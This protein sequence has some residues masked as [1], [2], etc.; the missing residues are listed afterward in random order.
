MKRTSQETATMNQKL[1]RLQKI[2]NQQNFLQT[3]VSWHRRP[4]SSLCSRLFE[5]LL[6]L[7][8][9][10]FIVA[11]IYFLLTATSLCTG[12]PVFSPRDVH[13][14][15]G[16]T[17]STHHFNIASPFLATTGLFID[18][19]VGRL[20][21]V[22]RGLVESSE[23]VTQ[24]QNGYLSEIRPG[25]FSLW[26]I[27]NNSRIGH[28]GR[29]GADWEY[30]FTKNFRSDIS[31]LLRSVP[32]LSFS[33]ETGKHL[34]KI[35]LFD[36]T[37]SNITM[38]KAV[39]L[40]ALE[41]D[42]ATSAR[43]VFFVNADCLNK[44]FVDPS[45]K[46]ILQQADHIFPDGI[47]LVVAGKMLK[48]PLKE[49][50]NGTDMLPY[51]SAMAKQKNK[52]FFLLGGK[53]GV[54]EEMAQ[55]L[56]NKM[57][58]AVAGYHHGYFDHQLESEP[59]IDEINRSGADILLVAFGAPLQEKWIAANLENLDP[60]I[61]MGVGGLF[62]FYSGNI[63]RAPRWLRELGLEWVYRILQEPGRM[64]QRYVIGNPL[65]LTR[66]IWWKFSAMNK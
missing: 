1:A 20:S 13:G 23:Y 9:L 36:I 33:S 59:I 26:S 63:K 57:G 64:W 8:V 45:Y 39:K 14:Q 6:I 46:Q 52:S 32:S 10:F 61:V 50:V 66:V 56:E 44:T 27:R 24:P 12:R 17:V 29:Q 3:A 35:N 22:G 34:E 7:P 21:L 42:T 55:Q 60:K 49:N 37:F 41:L 16:A 28:E 5:L 18:V 25:I 54:A 19:M 11:P 51:L 58:V 48:N 31:L 62:D 4:L 65:F 30:R 38:K 43:G 2:V 40:L 47:G 53:P 15:G